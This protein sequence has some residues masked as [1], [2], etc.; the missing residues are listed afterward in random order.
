MRDGVAEGRRPTGVADQGGDGDGCEGAGGDVN[1][2]D[3]RPGDPAED[4][5]DDSGPDP[6]RFNRWMKRSATGAV[7][8]GVALGLQQ[9]LERRD[10]RPAFVV[11][12]PGEPE[13]E[14]AP[15]R[16]RFDPDDP[17]NTV[18]IVRGGDAG[19]HPDERPASPEQ[20]Q[21]GR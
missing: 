1:V 2:G 3:D 5:H 9:A 13:D 12:A 16:L 17:S 11:E 15:I 6:L 21:S 4:T 19:R 14:D 18:A 8:T 20:D 7:L 10:Q